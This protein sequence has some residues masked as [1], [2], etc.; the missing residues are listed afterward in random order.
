MKSK[1]SFFPKN[2]LKPVSDFL[3]MRLK[4]LKIN[5]NKISSED[6]FKD[7]SRLLDN[8]AVDTEAE[9]QYGHARVGAIK[10][11][12]NK[13]ANQI[14]KALKRIKRGKYGICED[15]QKMIDTDRLAAYP[16]ATMCIVC[17]KKREQ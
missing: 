15:C 14:E 9:E 8:A 5:K 3:W 6:P 4:N 17:E 13:R 11:E 7:K 12:L 1:H 2:L 16:E 10:E